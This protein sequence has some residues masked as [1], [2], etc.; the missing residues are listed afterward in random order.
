ML[1]SV[2]ANLIQEV[3]AR[4]CPFCGS[5]LPAEHDRARTTPSN[6][7]PQV[8]NQDKT[9]LV[10]ARCS[11]TKGAFLVKFGQHEDGWIAIGTAAS[12]E[13]R[14]RNPEFYRSE[15]SGKLQMRSDYPGCPHCSNR[16]LWF[17]DSCGGHMSCC[18]PADPRATCP[19]CG[20]SGQLNKKSVGTL[21][22]LTDN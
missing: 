7:N 2:C 14:F 13:K 22:G 8:A 20:F 15:V 21:R 12:D 6:S 16:A 5:Q 18:H 9:V 3:E 11:K 1:C 10:P 4:F 19:W 17:C